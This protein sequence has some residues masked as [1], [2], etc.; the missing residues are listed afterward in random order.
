VGLENFTD[1]PVVDVLR[2]GAP[3]LGTTLLPHDTKTLDERTAALAAITLE[4]A[5][6]LFVFPGFINN[7]TRGSHLELRGPEPPAHDVPGL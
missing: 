1:R 2:K 7:K 4:H 3:K 6:G 5:N